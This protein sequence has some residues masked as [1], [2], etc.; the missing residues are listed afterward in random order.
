MS[1]CDKVLQNFMKEP[2]FKELW[3][4]IGDINI[5]CAICNDATGAGR[6]A[7]AMIYD[8]GSITICSNRHV[9]EESIQQSITHELTHAYD[10]RLKR[11]N[12]NDCEGL[13]ASEI[14]AAKNAECDKFFL[15]DFFKERCI[16]NR[17]T[18]ST[19]V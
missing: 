14:R 19:A 6:N 10:Y 16:I 12:F 3:S 18:Q 13:A 15:F 1:D 9:S 7:K 17:A 11:Y 4:S 2:K 8:D 5:S